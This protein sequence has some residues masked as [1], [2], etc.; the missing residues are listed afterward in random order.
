MIKSRSI[1]LA[2]VLAGLLALAGPAAADSITFDYTSGSDTSLIS[3]LPNSN[4]GNNT[5]IWQWGQ[6]S[7]EIQSLIQFSD[8]FG[9]NPGEI[10]LGSTITNALLNV[11]IYNGSAVARQVYQLTTGW[12]ANSATWN[13]MGGGVDVAS[14]TT[15]TAVTG[16]TQRSSGW[17]GLDV[18]ASLQDWANGGG[19]YGWAI[20]SDYKNSSDWSSIYSLNASNLGLR[21]TLTVSYDAPSGGAPEPGTLLLLG[22]GLA[23]F[24]GWR[25]RRRGRG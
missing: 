23:G 12:S 8:I 15:G 25:R 14:Q 4:Y 7:R 18:T 21:P 6:S 17:L 9:D 22:S 11:Y 10:P 16:Y 20:I 1:I 5:V 3:Y 24:W 2:L 13:S 19:N